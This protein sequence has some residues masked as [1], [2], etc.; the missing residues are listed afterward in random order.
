M[1]C[2]QPYNY[3]PKLLKEGDVSAHRVHLMVEDSCLSTKCT[4]PHATYT[5]AQVN[6]TNTTAAAGSTLVPHVAEG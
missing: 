6:G 5:N 3:P 1:S 2:K 4:L